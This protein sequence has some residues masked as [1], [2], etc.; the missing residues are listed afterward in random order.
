MIDKKLYAILNKR[1]QSNGGSPEDDYNDDYDDKQAETWD[2]G[3]GSNVEG[4]TV[5][6]YNSKG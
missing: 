6:I 4:G 5:I 2:E 3:M 1:I